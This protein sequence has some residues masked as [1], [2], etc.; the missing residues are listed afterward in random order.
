M[1]VTIGRRELLV[2]L[3]GGLAARSEGAAGGCASDRIY[4]ILNW[5]RASALK[6]ERPARANPEKVGHDW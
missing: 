1:T 2:A 3:G 5:R 6:E 4:D